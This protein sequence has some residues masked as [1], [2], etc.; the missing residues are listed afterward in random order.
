MKSKHGFTLLEVLIALAI[1]I[2]GIVAVM[3]LFPRSLLN[4]RVAA[5]R[6]VTAELANSVMGQIRASS[7]EALFGGRLPDGL[8]SV[9]SSYG[10]YSAY[11]TTVQRLNGSGDTFLQQVTFTVTFADG[12][13]EQFT[14]YVARQ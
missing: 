4:A 14:T 13:E 11:T 9:Y 12:R 2:I 8:L 7:A 3:Q 10:L 6:T 1:L 5:E